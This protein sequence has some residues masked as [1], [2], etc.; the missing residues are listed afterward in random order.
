VTKAIET[1]VYGLKC[2]AAGCGYID[3]SV[4]FLDYEKHLNAPCP[5]CGANL[6]TEA[7]YQATKLMLAAVEWLN[8]ITP[9][10]APR[11]DKP[12]R[13]RMDLD[14]SG[15]PKFVFDPPSRENGGV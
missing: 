11:T 5:K 10:D 14:G 7:D 8:A 1:E 4:S 13:I 6:L 9:E 15:I 12:T 2:D 3:K